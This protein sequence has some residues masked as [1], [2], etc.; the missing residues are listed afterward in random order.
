MSIVRISTMAGPAGRFSY[1]KLLKHDDCDEDDDVPTAVGAALEA[2]R[3]VLKARAW[4]RLRRVPV[5]RRARV[6]GLG[7]GARV[8]RFVVSRRVRLVRSV[9]GSWEKVARRVRE[10]QA[11]FGDLFAGNYMFLQV[12]PTPLR[13]AGAD[14]SCKA[15]FE[16]SRNLRCYYLPSS[17]SNSN[18]KV[19]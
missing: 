7:L 5:G 1:R 11:H 2:A 16:D 18:N 13:V 9:K 3:A 19:V 12:N 15:G 8:R 10:S 17:I 14:R 4:S 6:R